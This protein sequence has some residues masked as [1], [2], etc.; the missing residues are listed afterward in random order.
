MKI[1]N[2]LI[3]L[4]SGKNLILP[5]IPQNIRLFLAK[6]ETSQRLEYNYTVKTEFDA[7]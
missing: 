4:K 5:E 7:K 6:G 1:S 2:L 3:V